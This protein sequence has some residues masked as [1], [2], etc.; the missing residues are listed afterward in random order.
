MRG[1]GYSTTI[2]CSLVVTRSYYGLIMEF[3]SIQQE[4]SKTLCSGLI[5]CIEMKGIIEKVFQNLTPIPERSLN[6]G[7]GI[8]IV[9]WL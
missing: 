5:S 3:C 1:K 6:N 2:S 9:S 4:Y 8:D 7:M